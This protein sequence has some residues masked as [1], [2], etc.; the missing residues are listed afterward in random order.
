MYPFIVETISAYRLVILVRNTKFDKVSILDFEFSGEFPIDTL[1]DFSV[2]L[3]KSNSSAL[4]FL[5]VV[6]LSVSV[7]FCNSEGYRSKGCSNSS[8]RTS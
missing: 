5:Q 8:F 1:D 7:L 6:W 2:R 3:H 4:Y